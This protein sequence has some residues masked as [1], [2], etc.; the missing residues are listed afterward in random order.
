MYGADI[1]LRVEVLGLV[2]LDFRGGTR[3]RIEAGLGS[4]L[5]GVRQKVIGFQVS[6][7][8][9]VL[10]QVTMCQ[11]DVDTTPLSL[12]E[13]TSNEPLTL[14]E[15][16]F[17]DVTLTIEKPPGGG[18]PLILTNSKPLTLIA[19]RLSWYPAQGVVYQ[20]R[21]PVDLSPVGKPGQV[22]ATLQQFPMT[23]S[24]SA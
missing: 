8:S 18:P 5:G 7:D 17:L 21:E 3:R 6:A 10:G 14:R 2:L 19:D 9:P 20:L 23:M 24:H 4:G 11:A 16:I 12:L 1:P 13:V 22:V 15:T